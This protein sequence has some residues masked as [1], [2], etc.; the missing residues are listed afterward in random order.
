[1]YTNIKIRDFKLNASIAHTDGHIN[2]KTRNIYATIYLAFVPQS[3]RE[4]V[5]LVRGGSIIPLN[6]KNEELACV[7]INHEILHLCCLKL[8]ESTDIDGIIRKNPKKREM[9]MGIV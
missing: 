9:L 8:D 4:N 1:M 6:F 7:C 3:L 5:G 2:E